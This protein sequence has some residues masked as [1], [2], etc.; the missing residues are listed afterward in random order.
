MGEAAVIVIVA[1]VVLGGVL[2][3]RSVIVR[4]RALA[5]LGDA[6]ITRSARGVSMR[7][8]L[9]GRAFAG[10]NPRRAN[11]TRGDLV[12]T[13]DRCLLSTNR[14]VIADIGPERGRLFT[15]ARC[16]GPGRLV[17]E[18]DVPRPDGPPTLYRVDITHPDA[19]AWVD[20]LAPFV[21]APAEGAPAFARKPPALHAGGA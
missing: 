12:L 5:R 1:V 8:L 18:G 2:Q 11:R 15:S 10:M 7:V 6:P 4:R 9:Q 14:G 16:T 20:A 13:A 21:R 3:L 17:I 19:L